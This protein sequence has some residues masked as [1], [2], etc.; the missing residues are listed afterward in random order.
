MKANIITAALA[1]AFVFTLIA[2]G[3]HG[4]E[5]WLLGS[6]S[7][8][9]TDSSSSVVASSSSSCDGEGCEYI[10]VPETKIR[11]IPPADQV[12]VKTYIFTIKDGRTVKVYYS[13]PKTVQ[14]NAKIL[15]ALPGSGREADII[16]DSFKYLAETENVIVISPEFS[17]AQFAQ[18]GNADISRNINNPENWT[19]NF[20]DD[21]FLDFK[22]QFSLPNS[23]YILYGFSEGGI[24]TQRAAMF[25]GS[26]YIEYLISSNSGGSLT[27]PDDQQ[28]YSNGIKNLLMYKDLIDK[29][30][31]KRMYLLSG[32][33]D[34]G[35]PYSGIEGT[36]RHTRALY[37]YSYSKEYCERNSLFFNMD[38]ITIDKIGHSYTG[39]R[40]YVI[41]IIKGIYDSKKENAQ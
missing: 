12:E 41:D 35:G 10:Y 38:F 14:A 21:V 30:F 39:M 8:E 29:N 31:G 15:I 37:F 23:K 9:E 25:S 33:A 1:L 7:S 36:T 18:Y 17:A 20:I 28:N 32:S 11:S 26:P 4:I 16:I 22:S 34:K 19:F 13:F 40:P 27:A 5:D 2:C 24:L 6:S 3:E